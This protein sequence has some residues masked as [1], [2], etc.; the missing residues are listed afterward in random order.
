MNSNFKQ[1]LDKIQEEERKSQDQLQIAN[2][3]RY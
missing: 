2:R 3:E 1:S